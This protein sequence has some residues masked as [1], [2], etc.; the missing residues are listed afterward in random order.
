MFRKELF[1]ELKKKK[2]AENPQ[3]LKAGGRAAAGAMLI[4][5]KLS[6]DKLL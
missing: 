3:P 1:R 5:S 6:A 4:G 2:K